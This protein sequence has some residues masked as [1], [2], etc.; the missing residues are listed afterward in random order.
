MGSLTSFQGFQPHFM[1]SFSKWLRYYHLT[2]VLNFSL[3]IHHGR[4]I[5]TLV[6][7][8]AWSLTVGSVWVS[9]CILQTST[10]FAY[11]TF[12]Y[13]VW[14]VK[15]CLSGYK[16]IAQLSKSPITFIAEL[17]NFTELHVAPGTLVLS[18]EGPCCFN[19]SL[20]HTQFFSSKTTLHGRSKHGQSGMHTH[21]NTRACS[22]NAQY[23]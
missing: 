13:I 18:A 1:S 4:L 3:M 23:T 15:L 11:I 22:T 6:L 19:T 17:C 10:A 21:T 14:P 12:S 8:K 20:C 16:V 7:V 9:G 5:I 2:K